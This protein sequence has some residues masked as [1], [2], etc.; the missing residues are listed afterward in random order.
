MIVGFSRICRLG[1]GTRLG[2]L[3]AGRLFLK[4]IADRVA[5]SL[6]SQAGIADLNGTTGDLARRRAAKPIWPGGR[7]I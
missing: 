3:T 6:K 5:E 2:K 7:G 1:K 4:E